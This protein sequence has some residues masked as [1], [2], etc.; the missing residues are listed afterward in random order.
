[1]INNKKYN[2]SLLLLIIVFAAVSNPNISAQTQ[3][4]LEKAV[5]KLGHVWCGVTANGDKGN[6]DYRAGFFPNDYDIL[7]MR[8]QYRDAWAGAGFRLTTTNWVD[9]VDSLHAV[10]VYGPTNEF[11]PVGKVVVPMTNYIRYKYPHEV[12]DFQ[13][14]EIEDFGTHDPAQFGDYTCDQLIEVT[15]ENILGVQIQRKIMA[16]S[17][18]FN[19]DYIIVDATFTNVTD[20]TLHDFY[21]NIESNGNNSVRSNGSN[22]SPASGERFDPATTW[23]HYYGGR[24]G[25]TLRVF[26]EYSADEPDIPGDNMGAPAPSQGGRLLN[27][28][29]IWYSILH[30]SGEAYENPAD[31]VDDFLQP[32][33]TYIGKSN[34]IPYND[35]GDEFG[36]K[37]FW[38][39][40]GAYSDFFPMSGETWPG[41][42]HGGNSD[43]Q[44]SADYSSHP[45]G[46]R[47]KNDSKMW[48]SFG[49]YTMAPGK[50]VHLVYASGYTGLSLETAKEVGNKWLNKTLEE[51]PG[52]PD[53]RTGYFPPNF[54]YPPGTTDM[55]KRKN[56]WLST[57]I[58]SVMQA[59]YRAKWNFEIGYRIPQA[60]PPPTSIEITGL[61]TGVEIRWVDQEAEMM[62]NFAGYRIMRRI[63]N[64]DTVFYEE[65]YSSGADDKAEEHLYVDK[66]VLIGAQ[67]YY[68]IQAKAKI[69]EDDPYADPGTRGKTIY[70]SRVLDPNI[71]WINPPHFSQ[72]DLS[73][74]RIVPN[75]YNINDPL[76]VEHGFTDQRAIQFFN[77]PGKVTIK[78]FTENGDHVQTLEHDSPV[79]SGYEN[80]NMITRNQQVINSG[81]Y[82]AVFEKPNG[83]ISHQKFLVIR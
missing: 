59:A 54:V 70:S 65:I 58:D 67:Y 32:K 45:A 37:N 43:E 10:A 5:M 28:K 14:V 13:E 57:S 52:I 12:V 46:T 51:P 38:A 4:E 53:P 18:N 73:E 79:S 16:W 8:G 68:Y 63:S 1:M 78:I 48:S 64:K 56:R 39:I 25:D 23:Q 76:L 44:N 42:Y 29:F 50:K 21:I 77:L 49:P 71:Y 74:I 30:A 69:A 20:D 22:P 82:I 61:G 17:Q 75:P 80:W 83:E 27:A 66:N 24:V 11:M 26:Y 47:Q 36:D 7:G 3:P 41:T 34:L 35:E 60:P 2:W 6:F 31:D 9:P 40:R 15:S 62:P 55:D 33:V 19:D 81:V 72:T